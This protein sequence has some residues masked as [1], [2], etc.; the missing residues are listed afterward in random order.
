MLLFL[1]QMICCV[2][3]AYVMVGGFIS[4]LA[5]HSTL[6]SVVQQAY[7]AAC[8]GVQGTVLGDGVK[9]PNYC[10]SR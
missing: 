2:A 8:M 5:V 9:A 10:S 6:L 3:V 4:R 7:K 1:N